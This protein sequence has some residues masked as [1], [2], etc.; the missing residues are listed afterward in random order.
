MLG[1]WPGLRTSSVSTR[2]ED[3]ST[4]AALTRANGQLWGRGSVALQSA[5]CMRLM[6]G[7]RHS[8]ALHG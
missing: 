5:G 1:S 3:F 6:A 7:F 8:V 2:P 4:G